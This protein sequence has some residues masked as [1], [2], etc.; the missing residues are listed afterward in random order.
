M[1]FYFF[2]GISLRLCFPALRG[3]ARP[4]AAAQGDR[5]GVDA[6]LV[7]GGGTEG[8]ASW[9]PKRVPLAIRVFVSFA[10]RVSRLS[11]PRHGTSLLWGGEFLLQLGTRAT[12]AS[13]PLVSSTPAPTGNGI[14]WRA[15]QKATFV[16]SNPT[17]SAHPLNTLQMPVRR[18]PGLFLIL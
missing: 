17:S 5:G 14:A 6:Y 1:I 18:I 16:G 10:N 11:Q 3:R 12:Q 8:D 7:T 2:P 9:H 4:F 13:P 15:R